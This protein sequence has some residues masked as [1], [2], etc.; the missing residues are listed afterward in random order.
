MNA[1]HCGASVSEPSPV[2][3]WL[4]DGLQTDMPCDRYI[5]FIERHRILTT[6]LLKQGYKYDHLCSYFKRFSGKYK[7][8][9]DKFK[10][11][12]KQHIKDG[13]PLPL[14]TVGR[15]NRMITVRGGL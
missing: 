5:D 11:T 14:N 9:F 7:D 12:L 2:A 8:I 4:V 1:K 10:I 13:I 6:R 3:V 15:L